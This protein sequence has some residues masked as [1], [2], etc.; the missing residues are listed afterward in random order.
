[1]RINFLNLRM[2]SQNDFHSFYLFVL[3]YGSPRL[4]S[5][6]FGDYHLGRGLTRL[7]LTF[8]TYMS[9]I[10]LPTYTPNYEIST[11]LPIYPPTHV[12]QG[13][14]NLAWGT[15][16]GLPMDLPNDHLSLEVT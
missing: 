12:G 9:P 16:E 10:Y 7:R 8:P 6:R 11:Y 15:I 3:D 5:Y 13:D 2:N 1:M 14:A 4:W